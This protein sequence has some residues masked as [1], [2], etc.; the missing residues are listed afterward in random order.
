MGLSKE[1]MHTDLN[2]KWTIVE[3]TRENTI[4]VAVTLYGVL[5]SMAG[6]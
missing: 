2:A 3:Q 4:P 6:I 1:K 5:L